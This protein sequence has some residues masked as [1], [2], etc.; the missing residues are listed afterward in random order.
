MKKTVLL[1]LAALLAGCATA[2]PPAPKPPLR[3]TL[4]A[5]WFDTAG[6]LRWPP[7]DGFSS[8]PT[9]MVLPPGMLLDRFGSDQGRFF[10]PKG[11]TYVA[12]ALP[13]DCA[14]EPYTTYRVKAPIFVWAGRAAPWFDQ[15]GGATQFETDASAA[16]LVADA[17]LEPVT[18]TAT[19]PCPTKP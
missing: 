8:T 18:G 12:R 1:L 10:S 6:H 19:V 13:Y 14:L 17:A 7:D 2:P 5:Q 4:A 3:S 15:S 11:A 9:P 16:Q